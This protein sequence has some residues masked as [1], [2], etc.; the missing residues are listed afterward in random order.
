VIDDPASLGQAPTVYFGDPVRLPAERRSRVAVI[1]TAG[2]PASDLSVLV[3]RHGA[4]IHPLGRVVRPSLL[5]V[6]R[7]GQIDELVRPAESPPTPPPATPVRVD[8]PPTRAAPRTVPGLAHEDRSGAGRVADPLEMEWAEQVTPGQVEVRLLTPSPRLDGLCEELP[9]N[10]ARRAVELVAYLALH[11]PDAVTSDRLRT[12]VLGSA[13][14]DAAAKTLFN[15]AHAAR[16]AMGQDGGGDSLFPGATRNGLYQVSALVTVDV[17]RATALAVQARDCEDPQLAI[18]LART[19]LEL[20]E[21]EPLANALAGY[22]WWEA[23]GH[24]ARI[25]SVLVEAA[26]VLAARATEAGSFEL[27]RLGLQRARLVAPYSEA[28]SRAAMAT[29][30]VEGDA[31]RLRDEWQECQRVADALDPGSSPSARA[32]S[33]YGELR[34]MVS[35]GSPLDR[36]QAGL[37]PID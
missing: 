26:C 2:V 28:L 27:A 20:V 23:E 4:T 18:A 19:A 16:R 34:Q 11:R 9:P 5:S 33:L 37:I 14:A 32:E 7:A 15:T 35:V 6:A 29:A 36:R 3:D 22:T 21:G 31:D 24:G 10:R 1:T 8:P 12:R 13:D 25:A 17:R 30:A